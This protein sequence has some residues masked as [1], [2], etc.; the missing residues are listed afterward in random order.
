MADKKITA[1]ESLGTTIASEDLFHVIDDPNNVPINKKVTVAQVFNNIPTW[2]GLD[3]EP[4]VITAAGEP[5]DLTTSITHLDTTSTAF[6]DP[7]NLTLADGSQGQIKII[8]MITHNG[9]A[10]VVP[11]SFASGSTIT[12]TAAGQ[13]VV[14]LFT[15][16]NWFV[17]GSYGVTIS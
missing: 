10:E 6:E 16:S 15:N 5:V 7:N 3:G 2:I 17:V 14:L 9:N 4:Q 1:L 8:T 12:F 13:S 11:V